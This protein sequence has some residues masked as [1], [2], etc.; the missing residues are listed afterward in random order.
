M[1]KYLEE[2]GLQYFWNKIKT[3][4]ALKV[5]EPAS[6][7]TSGQ[8]LTTDGNG[9]RSWTTFGG[10]GAELANVDDT[11]TVTGTGSTVTQ[12][13]TKIGVS[14]GMTMHVRNISNPDALKGDWYVDVNEDS[15]TFSGKVNGT[16]NISVSFVLNGAEALAEMLSQ[17]DI[18]NNLTTDDSTKVA[19]ANTVKTLSDT[20]VDKN[21]LDARGFIQAVGLTSAPVSGGN[22]SFSVTNPAGINIAGITL[23]QY[24]KGY[25]VS[26]GQGENDA[27][28]YAIDSR[29]NF[30][31][32]FRNGGTWQSLSKLPYRESVLIPHV[33]EF[34]MTV[35][36]GYYIIPTSLV[37]KNSHPIIS[38]IYSYGS[39]MKW[40]YTTQN[41]TSATNS[42]NVYVRDGTGAAPTNGTQIDVRVVYFA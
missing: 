32:G 9:G 10:S 29:G 27:T 41:N 19:S 40:I 42:Y 33:V 20:K 4:L 5:N 31:Y 12:T 13:Y 23:P 21:V 1:S 39:A 8:V 2:S 34:T 15:Y 38:E 35:N 26:S 24:A 7:G 3:V 25:I 22:M 14:S 16:T 17:Q 28:M 6:E 18:V 30:Y 37:P 11:F 36:S